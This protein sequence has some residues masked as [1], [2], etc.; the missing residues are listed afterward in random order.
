MSIWLKAEIE[1][2]RGD[3]SDAEIA[4]LKVILEDQ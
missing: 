1:E 4:E 3:L 2:D